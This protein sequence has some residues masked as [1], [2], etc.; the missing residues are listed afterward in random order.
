MCLEI[1]VITHITVKPL[2]KE[3]IQTIAKSQEIV[4]QIDEMQSMDENKDL[5]RSIIDENVQLLQNKMKGTMK[6]IV[7]I[8]KTEEIDIKDE[9]KDLLRSIIDENEQLQNSIK[10]TV[11]DV[12][13]VKK[14][15]EIDIKDE[16][17]DILRSIID[18]NE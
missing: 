14:T 13:K 1:I 4:E 18:E 3:D 6:V 17:N 11:E 7:K 10:E 9:N 2:T 15:E 16:N 8:D 12:V 5:L